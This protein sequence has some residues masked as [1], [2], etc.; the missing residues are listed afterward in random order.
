MARPS[1][2]LPVDF[3]EPSFRVLDGHAEI[4]VAEAAEA[5]LS[6]PRRVT[7]IISA[8]CERLGAY[9]VDEDQARRLSSAGREWLLQ[10]S[11]L[12][13]FGGNGWFEAPCRHC[14]ARF[15]IDL[16]LAE[17]PTSPAG[18]GFPEIEVETSL[19]LRLFEAPNGAHEEQL[20]L[21]S[22]GDPRRA[23]AALC[24]LSDAAASEAARFGEEDLDRIDAA[25][26]AVSPDIADCLDV[27]CP[28]CGESVEV[29]IDPLEFAFPRSDTILREVHE[30]A[31]S[32]HWSEHAILDLPS[33]R[34]RTYAA[35]V[36]SEQVRHVPRGSPA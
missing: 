29:R 1:T 4:A 26:E 27:A 6:R 5:S 34:R 19:G 8:L 13:F 22:D 17:V 32:Y 3:P 18:T 14:G 25:L 21:R 12:R 20:S 33:S 31:G 9:P 24:G 15:D 28:E 10:R 16:S 11:G 35:L 7:A 36:R 23:L 2:T 30:I